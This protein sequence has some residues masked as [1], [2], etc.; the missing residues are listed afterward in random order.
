MCNVIEESS[1]TQVVLSKGIWAVKLK[2]LQF[3]SGDAGSNRLTFIMA[4]EL[5][6]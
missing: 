4:V 3:L 6:C 2:T 5:Y 1:N